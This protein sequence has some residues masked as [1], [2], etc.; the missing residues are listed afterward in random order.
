MNCKSGSQ[1]SFEETTSADA[2]R[3]V[4]DLLI[5]HN[6]A[7]TAVSRRVPLQ[8]VARRSDGAIVGGAIGWTIHHW[9]YV[10][11]LALAPDVRGTGEGARLL[12]EVE[13]VARARGCVGVHLSSYTFQAP[14]FYKRQGYAEFGRIDGLPPGHSN[15][16]LMKRI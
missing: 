13:R 5:A 9:C 2:A 3:C 6:D 8:V 16:W 7:H 1:L 12:E 11:I 14:E 4:V 10:D 15:V